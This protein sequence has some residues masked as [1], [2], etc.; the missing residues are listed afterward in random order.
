MQPTGS[1]LSLLISLSSRGGDRSITVLIH[2]DDRSYMSLCV[3][4]AGAVDNIQV[5]SIDVY[6]GLFYLSVDTRTWLAS[7]SCS[8][9]GSCTC[10][11]CGSG[12]SSL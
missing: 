9:R 12:S 5:V 4:V 10:T 11:L 6:I 2:A 1:T 8:A 3:I 7:I